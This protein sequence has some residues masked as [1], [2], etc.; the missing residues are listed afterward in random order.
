MFIPNCLR[1]HILCRF[2]SDGVFAKIKIL[3]PTSKT[4]YTRRGPKI[5]SL[6]LPGC[7]LIDAHTSSLLTSHC[8]CYFQ[9]NV[10]PG[11]RR[12]VYLFPAHIF[13]N[14]V[15]FLS[16]R[17]TCRDHT[18]PVGINHRQSYSN[19]AQ[20]S[21]PFTSYDT[22]PSSQCLDQFHPRTLRTR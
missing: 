2:A 16:D 9:V 22:L 13:L 20:Q 5:P 11:Y 14:N 8:G 12:R 1:Q 7:P 6:H 10:R 21:H 3:N 4:K 19:Y 17:R 15:R 18:N